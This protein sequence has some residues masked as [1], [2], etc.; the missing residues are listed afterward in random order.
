MKAENFANILEKIEFFLLN[1]DLIKNMEFLIANFFTLILL[2][3][4]NSK[5][6]NEIFKFFFKFSIIQ[7]I[8]GTFDEI[9]QVT[10]KFYIYLT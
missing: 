3:T 5:I 2:S 10:S 1:E 9:C 4:K 7:K 6:T 8:F